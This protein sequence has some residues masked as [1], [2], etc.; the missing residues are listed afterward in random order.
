MTHL[1]GRLF[2]LLELVPGDVAIVRAIKQGK[3]DASWA[4]VS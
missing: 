2:E 1:A 3:D 4:E